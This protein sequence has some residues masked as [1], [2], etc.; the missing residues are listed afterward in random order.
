MFDGI[1][2]FILELVRE[3]GPL[4]LFLAAFIENAA[5]LSWA[6]PGEHLLAV[7][8]Y[9]IHRG[10]LRFELAW[11]YVFLGVLC[12]DHAG[13]CVGRY[14]G[15]RLAHRLPFPRAIV[16]VEQ[17]VRRHG[18]WV[19]LG[20]RFTGALRP[21]VLFTVGAMGLPYRRFWLF[22]VVGAASWSALWLGLGVLGGTLLDAVGGLGPW[23]SWLFVG[24]AALGGLL[25][26]V[27]RVPLKR[28][29]FGGDEPTGRTAQAAVQLAR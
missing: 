25:A 23:G 4:I 10:E 9:F 8:G 17:F 27:F 28:L 11:V 18:G 14:G 3:H 7:G 2:G 24:S 6:I 1:V 20:G 13:Y 16:R 21:A 15:R 19:V 5:F 22:E 29:A 12:G 26:W